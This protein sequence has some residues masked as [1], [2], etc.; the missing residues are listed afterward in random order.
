MDIAIFVG[1]QNF[2][3]FFETEGH[4]GFTIHGQTFSRPAIFGFQID[5]DDVVF[6]HHGVGDFANLDG[7]DVAF[8]FDDGHMFLTGTVLGV[9]HQQFHI[10]TT[11]DGGYAA[12]LDDAEN[13]ATM[14]TTIKF[15]FVTQHNW[16]PKIYKIRFCNLYTSFWMIKTI[17]DK[18]SK[19]SAM[20]KKWLT[21]AKE[22]QAIAQAGV[23]YTKDKYELERYGRLRELSVEIMAHYT[24]VDEEKVRDLFCFERGYQTPKVDVRG[25]IIQDDRI[26]LVQES[27]DNRWALPGGWADIGLSA[28]E[29]IRKEMEEEAGLTVDV[30]RLVAVLDWISNTQRAIPYAIYKVVM[31]CE[32]P[33]GDFVENIETLASGYF[34]LND[35]PPLSEER[36]TKELIQMCYAAHRDRDF[37]PVVD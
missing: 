19:G 24:E 20:E 28:K 18:E 25:A 13:I 7:D 9:G 31:L 12:V 32:N 4:L 21:W 36:T 1:S 3:S 17:Y 14:I 34:P 30:G 29:N 37:I 10:F 26:F 22:I 2:V 33:R 15:R 16:P 8:Y 5:P 11:A 23:F 27:K 6:R 35:L